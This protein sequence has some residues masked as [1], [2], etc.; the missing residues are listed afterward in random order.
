MSTVVR[1]FLPDAALSTEGLREVV[2]HLQQDNIPQAI[3]QRENSPATS[4]PDAF[5]NYPTSVTNMSHNCEQPPAAAMEPNVQL[6]ST[7]ALLPNRGTLVQDA[8]LSVRSDTRPD[9][10]VPLSSRPLPGLDGTIHSTSPSNQPNMSRTIPEGDV[11]YTNLISPPVS[12]TGETFPIESVPRRESMDITSEGP[13]R[14]AEAT[15]VTDLSG[16]RIRQ[17]HQLVQ[18]LFQDTCFYPTSL[19]WFSPEPTIYVGRNHW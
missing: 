17:R 18:F 6:P 7:A 8:L 2:S 12:W 1:H 3:E 9:T 4:Q 11:G 10:T 5:A 14:S 16:T 19:R 15:E 13:S